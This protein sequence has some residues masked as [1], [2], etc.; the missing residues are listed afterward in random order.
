MYINQ[1]G[2]VQ[3]QL[4]NFGL[5]LLTLFFR[6]ESGNAVTGNYSDLSRHRDNAA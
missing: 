2:M 4:L 1:S 3:V 5:T 6:N